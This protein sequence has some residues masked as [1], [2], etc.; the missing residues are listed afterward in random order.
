MKITPNFWNGPAF[1]AGQRIQTSSLW[2][3]SFLGQAAAPRPDDFIAE[4]DS[5]RDQIAQLPADAA[6]RITPTVESCEVLLRPENFTP[7][8]ARGCLNSLLAQIRAAGG[9]I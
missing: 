1:L 6:A 4:F 3:N 5:Y 8:R 7:I 9:K 2:S